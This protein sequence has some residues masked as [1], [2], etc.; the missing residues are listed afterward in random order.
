MKQSN[1]E[2][3][4]PTPLIIDNN[5]AQLIDN[6][7]LIKQRYS[8]LADFNLSKGRFSLIE[9]FLFLQKRIYVDGKQLRITFKPENI[10]VAFES[11]SNGRYGDT[12]KSKFLILF[13]FDQKFIILI[14]VIESFPSLPSFTQLNTL[15]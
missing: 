4:E 13:I 11:I 15:I 6:F 9:S 1:T 3:L 10:F 12:W 2:N 7:Q 8:S 14:L 5:Q